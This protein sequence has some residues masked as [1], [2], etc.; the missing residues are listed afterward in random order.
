MLCLSADE[1][2]L[3][4]DFAIRPLDL[5]QRIEF[6]T[7]SKSKETQRVPSSGVWWLADGLAGPS[8]PVHRKLIPSL[9]GVQSEHAVAASPTSSVATV[10]WFV[11][12]DMGALLVLEVRRSEALAS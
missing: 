3:P 9:R 8:L 12:S 2:I 11:E 1:P 5:R 10:R 4:E 7:L 6:N